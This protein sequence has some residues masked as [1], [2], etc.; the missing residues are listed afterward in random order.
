[1]RSK[2]PRRNTVTSRFIEAY[3]HLIQTNQV[4]DTADFAKRT[5]LTMKKMNKVLAG[6]WE[7]GDMEASAVGEAFPK[8]RMDWILDG[9]GQML[10]EQ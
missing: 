4:T 1:M 9:E 3:N 5:G 7:V 8:F 2:F 10:H 6:E